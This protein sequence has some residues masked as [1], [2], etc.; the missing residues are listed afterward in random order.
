[1]V[2]QTGTVRILDGANKKLFNLFQV[3][4][5]FK[6]QEKQ[7]VLWNNDEGNENTGHAVG[8][9]KVVYYGDPKKGLFNTAKEKEL[10]S[11]A[12]QGT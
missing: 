3:K 1:M 8:L 10:Q 12:Q 9:R 11:L 5:D 7:N 2:G 6:A 4:L